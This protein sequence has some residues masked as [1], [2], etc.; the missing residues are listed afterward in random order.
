MFYKEGKLQNAPKPFNRYGN[1]VTLSEDKNGILWF[2]TFGNGLLRY[3]KG[4]ITQINTVDG[5]SNDYISSSFYKKEHNILWIGT[6]YGVSKIQLD[7]KSTVISIDN[8]LNETNCIF[9]R[10]L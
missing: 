10:S 1:F 7:K 3:A 9:R 6:M 8:Y 4:K 5:L 2:G